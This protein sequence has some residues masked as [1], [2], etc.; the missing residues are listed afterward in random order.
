MCHS[1]TL[2]HEA[3]WKAFSS[4]LYRREEFK[5]ST[6]GYFTY[7]III[8]LKQTKDN[9]KK[10][11]INLRATYVVK[12]L[13]VAYIQAFAQSDE[14]LNDLNAYERMMQ[15]NMELKHQIKLQHEQSV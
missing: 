2:I 11:N 7:N 6:F 3:T 10:W 15:I 1:D 12:R 8:K 5:A 4:V 14:N 13:H 9:F